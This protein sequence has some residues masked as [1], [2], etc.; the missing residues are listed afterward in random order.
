MP[1][2]SIVPKTSQPTS[3]PQ[4]S[5][6]QTSGRKPI[7]YRLRASKPEQPR[8]VHRAVN[9]R[10]R[11]Q[12]PSW[13]SR[14]PLLGIT[15]QTIPP[16]GE[17][18]YPEGAPSLRGMYPTRFKKH[19]PEVSEAGFTMGN[20]RA[21]AIAVR[22]KLEKE[23]QQ[24]LLDVIAAQVK[25]PEN[26][27]QRYNEFFRLLAEGASLNNAKAIAA[28]AD[29]RFREWMRK[30]GDAGHNKGV[31]LTDEAPEPYRTFALAVRAVQATYNHSILTHVN[32]AAERDW[33]AGAWLLERR[34]PD[35]YGQ[36]KVGIGVQVNDGG[37][38]QVLIYVP[39][40]GREAQLGGIANAPP[41]DSF[42]DDEQGALADVETYTPSPNGSGQETPSTAS[43]SEED[44]YDAEFRDLG[45]N[46]A[47]SDTARPERHRHRPVTPTDAS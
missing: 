39:E 45:D 5:G 9:P 12:P 33:K 15:G 7:S 22:Y 4:T 36:S 3:E 32:K 6:P 43:P 34:E 2:K 10:S 28:V 8:P 27:R 20:R 38:A 30:G 47:R 41:T 23:Q 19:V 29:T 42:L 17:E 40:N 21:K 11:R 35:T 18:A 44:A 14:A 16:T 46:A 1:R 31:D 37:K 13:H 25:F 24:E 26:D